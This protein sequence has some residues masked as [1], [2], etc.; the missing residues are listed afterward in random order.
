MA[1]RLIRLSADLFDVFNRQT[2]TSIDQNFEL[3]GAL[4][5]VDYS[6]PLSYHRPFYA[7]FSVRFEF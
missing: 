6:K 2:I 4:P 5:N 3:S 1:L 7:R